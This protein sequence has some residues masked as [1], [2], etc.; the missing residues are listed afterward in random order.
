VAAAAHAPFVAAASPHLFGMDRFDEVSRPRDLAMRF[1]GIEYAAWKSFRESE[2]S[3][4]VALTLPRVLARLPYGANF[5]TVSEFNFEELSNDDNHNQ[6]LWMS[7]AW[8]YAACVTAAFAK[9]GW[10]ARTRGMEGGGRAE[11]LPLLSLPT[12][13]GDV[14]LNCPAEVAIEARREFVLSSLGFL[15]LLHAR[16]LDMVVFMGA[17][18]CQKPRRL[19]YS[20][21]A[22]R[23]HAELSSMLNLR[24][25]ACRFAH[26]LTVM[27]LG[28]VGAFMAPAGCARW[29]N[30][31]LSTYVADP[32]AEAETT[33][34]QRPL[35]AARV[36]VRPAKDKPR[37][38][39]LVAY[40]RPAYQLGQLT[41]ELR[42]VVRVPGRG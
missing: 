14:A 35:A 7:A 19:P 17:Q 30:G 37:Q 18:T 29:L 9:H 26:Y 5:K 13:D 11:G 31:W 27:T 3:A 22:A 2:D 1:E 36:E 4:Y 32:A 8:A 24:L 42:L 23:A 10:F 38:C 12:D 40:L 28:T 34:R 41:T 20:D 39:E 16:H 15:P 6:H 33:R 21:P 25:C